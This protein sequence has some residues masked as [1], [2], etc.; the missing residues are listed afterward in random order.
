MITVKLNEANFE[1]DIYSLLKAF[2]PQEEILVDVNP[3]AD[4]EQ[5]SFSFVVEYAKDVLTITWK[6]KE[7]EHTRSCP[8]HYENRKDTKNR[9]KRLLYEILHEIS[10]RELP[11]GTLTG[12]RPTK[13]PLHMLEQGADEQQIRRY[14]KETYL[15]SEEKE[16]LCTQIAQTEHRLLT[17][18]DYE[19]GYSVYIGIPF[20]PSTCLYCSFTSYPIGVWK[21]RVDEYLDALFKE[22]DF[23]A[24]RM[25]GKT[26]DT[27]YIGGGT[28]TSLSA[29]QL[30]RLFTKI[31]NTLDLSHLLEYTVEAGRPDSITREK[32]ETIHRHGIERISINPQTMNQ[33]TLDLIGRHHSVE[34][35]I[36]S[37]HLAREV[38]IP[39][40]NMDLIVGL[41]GEHMEDVQHTMSVIRDLD[42][43]NLTVHS[44]AIKRSA[45]LNLEWEKYQDMHM[46]NSE[47]HMELAHQTAAEL[48]MQPYYLYR[49]KN[50]TGNLENIGFAKEG[51]AGLYNILIMEEKQT[52]LALGAGA[53]CKYVSDHGQTVT[54]SENVKDVGLYIER[55]DE[56][57]ARK[58]D[59]IM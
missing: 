18:I 42:P 37:Y 40:I 53:A 25:Q 11:W 19:N 17:P 20:C 51:K 9:L 27:I 32:L 23:V 2:Y 33:K 59:K 4:Q 3:K 7:T 57:I 21:K 52:I 36:E 41:P 6:I 22:I 48:N 8:V 31:E 43:D 45:R 14:M 1:Y 15:I 49:Q 24:E 56:M 29:E 5:V 34:E 44:L 39:T 55:I 12:I 54:R 38:G 58:K 28:P 50:M 30:E 13:I 16:N 10:G 47:K 46:E 35:V 26:L